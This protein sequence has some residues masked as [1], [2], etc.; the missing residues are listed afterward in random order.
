MKNRFDFS[1]DNP[2]FLSPVCTR[3]LQCNGTRLHIEQ[4]ALLGESGIAGF[5]DFWWCDDC[6]ET[7]PIGEGQQ[8]EITGEIW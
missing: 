2:L 4:P 1:Q 3:C 6:G 5:C 7:V 8:N